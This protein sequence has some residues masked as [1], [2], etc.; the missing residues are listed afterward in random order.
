MKISTFSLALALYAGAFV[1]HAETNAQ[2]L[3]EQDREN[4][5]HPIRPG[6]PGV[7]PFW[8]KAT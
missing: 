5:L 6:E 2:S 1:L 3:R 8:N 7:R 4:S